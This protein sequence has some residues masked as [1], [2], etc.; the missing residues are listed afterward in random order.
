[1]A[2]LDNI[3]TELKDRQ[4]ECNDCG[5][6]FYQ[7]RLEAADANPFELHEQENP[8]CMCIDCYDCEHSNLQQ[9][10]ECC[11]APVDPDIGFCP[12]CREHV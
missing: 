3:P 8:N 10:S 9:L 5:A 11:G 4:W 1:M 12:K 7:G 6:M 2:F